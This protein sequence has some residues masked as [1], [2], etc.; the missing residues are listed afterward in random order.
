[1]RD[2]LSGARLRLTAIREADLAVIE[3]W[4]NDGHFM[5]LYD[6]LPALPKQRGDVQEL[7][8]GFSGTDEKYIFAARDRETEEIIGILGFDEIIWSNGVANL[9]IGIGAHQHTAKGLGK[10]ASQL[11]LDF[12]FHELNFHRIQLQVLAYNQ[13]AIKL[14]EGLG[15]VRE[16]TYR[17]FI[18]RDGKRYDMYLYG[19]LREEWDKA[20]C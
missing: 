8:D 14:Y 17:Q 20:S 3:G 4:F 15:F 6:M 7:L 11:L 18:L 1:M 10:E 5:R 2:L 9:F 16:G 13:A 19:L 12:G